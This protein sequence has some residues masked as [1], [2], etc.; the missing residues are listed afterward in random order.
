MAVGKLQK[1]LMFLPMMQ[2]QTVVL[3]IPPATALQAPFRLF[4]KLRAHQSTETKW[5]P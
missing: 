4:Q 3:I 2:E 1:S 5:E